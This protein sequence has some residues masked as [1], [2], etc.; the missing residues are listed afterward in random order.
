MD[1]ELPSIGRL[2]PELIDLF[3]MMAA[4][5]LLLLLMFFWALFFRK[6]KKQRIRRHKRRRPLNPTLAKT[7][8]LPPIRQE[9]DPATP[10]TPP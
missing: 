5:G 7:G 6:G 10:T 2:S 1:N 3:V 4:L 9:K 8:G